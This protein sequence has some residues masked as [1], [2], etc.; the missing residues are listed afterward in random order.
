[1]NREQFSNLSLRNLENKIEQNKIDFLSVA[2][3][4]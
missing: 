4:K 1:M 3:L 2:L